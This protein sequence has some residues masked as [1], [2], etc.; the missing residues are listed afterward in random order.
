MA[1]DDGLA[2]LVD[3]THLLAVPYHPGSVAIMLYGLVLGVDVEDFLASLVD[4][5]EGFAVFHH[6]GDSVAETGTPTF[7]LQLQHHLASLVDEA[8]S[9]LV[10]ISRDDFLAVQRIM[11]NAKYG[12][13]S[14]LPSLQVIP[15]GLL[16][17]FVIIHPKWGSFRMDDY[18]QASKSVDPLDEDLK[19]EMTMEAHR[20]EFDL[21]G[22]EVADFKLFDDHQVPSVLLQKSEIRF[23]IPC[24][25]RMNCGNQVELLV[26]PLKKQIAV[27]PAMKDERC[28]IQWAGGSGR[29]Q[30]A[31]MVACRA[32]ID[33]IFEIFGWKDDYKYKLYG[34]IYHDGKENACIFS[35]LSAS[36]FINREDYLSTAG[37]DATGQLLN[38]SG[39]RVRAVSGNLG[40]SFGNEYY[41]ER[42]LNELRH[43]SS[44]E[45]KTRIEGQIC[46]TGPKLNITSYETLRA[47]IKEELG[48]LF[49][50]Q[51]EE[52]T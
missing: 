46:S 12:G 25:R 9:G 49:E 18:I 34:C 27:R 11:N 8:L 3:I 26:H 5:I 35:D 32:F 40:Y 47:F 1:W 33:T 6:D 51:E 19:E 17:G 2:C 48:D 42:S 7:V 30:E 37:V 45:W 28:A 13:T 36:V 10:L 21:R 39:K 16:K 41:V 22:Y 15:E 29:M 31:R 24:I 52:T 50:E 23:N 14:L 20:G 38:A 4:T 43:M 44:Q